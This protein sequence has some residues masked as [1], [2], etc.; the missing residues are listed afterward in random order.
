MIPKKWSFK[1]VFLIAKS[2]GKKTNKF[3][4]CKGFLLFEKVELTLTIFSPFFEL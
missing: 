3:L 4:S 2:A 1:A